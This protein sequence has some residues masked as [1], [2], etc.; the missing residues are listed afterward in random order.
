MILSDKLKDGINRF[1]EK[2]SFE[3]QFPLDFEGS[4]Y[5]NVTV[6]VHLI[7]INHYKLNGNWTPHLRY[8]LSIESTNNNIVNLMYSNDETITPTSPYFFK[9]SNK[10]DV[11]SCICSCFC[12][13]SQPIPMQ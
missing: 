8:S 9:L 1:L 10:V 2:H 11:P 7:D 6:K 13:I 5:A 4:E 3:I 12:T